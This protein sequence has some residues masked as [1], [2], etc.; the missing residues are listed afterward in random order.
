MR[1]ALLD[2]CN[3][4]NKNKENPSIHRCHSPKKGDFIIGVSCRY[5]PQESVATTG[6]CIQNHS[7]L[8][9]FVKTRPEVGPYEELDPL[10]LCLDQNYPEVL[11]L[12]C[13]W[14]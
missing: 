11:F 14:I 1:R 2:L 10:G 7:R 4:M 5:A 9:Y 12:G 3:A 6:N 13:P 8:T